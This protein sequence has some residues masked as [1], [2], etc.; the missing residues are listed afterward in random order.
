MLSPEYE[1]DVI[2]IDDLTNRRAVV[3]FIWGAYWTR[4]SK[5]L[6]FKDI[7]KIADTD[8]S[9]DN[10]GRLKLGSSVKQ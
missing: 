4:T 7:I 6:S 5:L 8:T 9:S 2:V 10:R 1:Y 3:I